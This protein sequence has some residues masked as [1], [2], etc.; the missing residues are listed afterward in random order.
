ML[1]IKILE[2]YT[3]IDE[4]RLLSQHFCQKEPTTI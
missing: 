2:H 1:E 3:Y 4:F